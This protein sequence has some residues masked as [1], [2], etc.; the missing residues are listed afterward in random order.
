MNIPNKLEGEIFKELHESFNTSGYYISNYGRLYSFKSKNYFRLKPRKTKYCVA[1]LRTNSKKQVLQFVHRLVIVSFKGLSESID[2]VIDHIDRNPSNNYL[3]NLRY[4]TKSENSKN[5]GIKKITS[6]GM[7]VI[8]V[9][10]ET[11]ETT[12]YESVSQLAKELNLTYK[13][14]QTLCKN[15]SIY[16]DYTLQYLIEELEG[17]IWKE[18]EINGKKLSASNKGRIK[19]KRNSASYGSKNIN[20]YF[21]IS[22]NKKCFF[23]HDIICETF[24]EPKPQLEYCVNH[25]DENPENNYAENLEWLSKGDNTRCYFN[26]S[27]QQFNLDGS[28]LKEYDGIKLASKVLGISPPDN[29]FLL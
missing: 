21:V 19:R 25:K 3:S 18:I 6:H 9:N 1:S 29:F 2:L 23:V 22:I 15:N 11:S 14:V 28:L 27:I 10:N 16:S 17:E 26:R 12:K 13:K 4:A 7:P 20:G 5:V 24:I 8:K